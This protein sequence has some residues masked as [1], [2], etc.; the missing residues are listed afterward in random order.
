MPSRAASCP[1]EPSSSAPSSIIRSA[2][3][4]LASVPAQAGVPGAASGRQRKQERYPSASAAAALGAKV[5]FSRF[6]VRA[7]HTGR[8]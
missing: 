1:T 7:G 6:G 8:Q 4:T 3:A 2:R 5:Q